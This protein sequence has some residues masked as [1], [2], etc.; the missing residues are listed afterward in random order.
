MERRGLLLL[1]LEVL[2]EVEEL[3]RPC[4]PRLFGTVL[5]NDE[6]GAFDELAP[7]A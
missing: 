7:P 6:G 1:E 2:E 4:C 3:D 5:L